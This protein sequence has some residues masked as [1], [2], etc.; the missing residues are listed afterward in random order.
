[1]DGETIILTA[2]ERPAAISF[3]VTVRIDGMR[4]HVDPDRVQ[5]LNPEAAP[6]RDTAGAAAKDGDEAPDFGHKPLG[7]TG[8][9]ALE[10]RKWEAGE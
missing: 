9:A 5:E 6:P 3:D 2:P 1:M 4:V 7:R 10:A 8:A